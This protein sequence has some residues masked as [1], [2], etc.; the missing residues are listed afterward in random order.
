MA[1]TKQPAYTY[2]Q[3]AFSRISLELWGMYH[4]PGWIELSIPLER[5]ASCLEFYLKHIHASDV[6]T[7]R[8]KV[9]LGRYSL[10]NYS[11][12]Y[13]L[14]MYMLNSTVYQEKPSQPAARSH[15]NNNT[16]NIIATENG[17]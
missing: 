3:F 15:N 12:N 7:A 1:H 14:Y 13:D 17:K 2:N 5:Q 6:C 4:D 8:Y 10:R 16:A 9:Q 11:D